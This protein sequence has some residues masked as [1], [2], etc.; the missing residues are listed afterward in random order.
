M[1]MPKLSGR[2]ALAASVVGSLLILFVGWFM[3]VSPQ[4]SKAADL[5]TKVSAAELQLADAQRLLASPNRKQTEAT[6]RAAKRAMP[7]TAQTSE[8]L[9]Q[10]SAIVSA[11]QTELDGISPSA[12]SATGGAEPYAIS[13]NMKGRYF[14]LQ[15]FVRLLNQ[16]ADVKNGRI[17]GK[18][19]LYTVDSIAFGAGGTEPGQNDVITA[20][21]SLNAFVYAPPVAAPAPT[22]T[23]TTTTSTS[24]T[25]TTASGATP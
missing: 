19:R 16:S 12:V 10:L 21:V 4:R 7:D 20:T 8:I 3:L 9:R 25:S 5:N 18:G 6:L 14:A 15:K 2:I 22:T 11:S 23:D 17:T 24:D 13:L 1:T